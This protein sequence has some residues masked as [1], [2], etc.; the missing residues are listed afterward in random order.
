LTTAHTKE[1]VPYF[2]SYGPD[3][4]AEVVPPLKL[5]EHETRA[6]ITRGVWKEIAEYNAGERPMEAFHA[7][8]RSDHA[9]DIIQ[10]IW[11]DSKRHYFVN[12]PNRGAVPNLPDDAFLELECV[13]GKEGPK[14]I[15]AP[16]MPLGLRGLQMQIM[17]THELTVEAYVK[18]DRGLLLRA[19]ATDPI[20]N[21]LAAAEKALTDLYEAEKDHLED[22]IAPT[23]EAEKKEFIGMAKADTAD[24]GQTREGN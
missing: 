1:Y 2:Q 19:L 16:E 6:E 17:D 4:E 18:K 23:P 11:N 13:C 15:P 12:T 20:I 22:W 10:A 5:F 24:Q 9:T 21:S 7:N 3:V 14:A 8:Y